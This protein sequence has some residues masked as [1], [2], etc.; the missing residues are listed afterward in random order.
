M[1]ASLLNEE[2][3]TASLEQRTLVILVG[4]F[5][6][7]VDLLLDIPLLVAD[8]T[9]TTDPDLVIDKAHLAGHGCRQRFAAHDDSGRSTRTSDGCLNRT[10]GFD[11]RRV[12]ICIH[13]TPFLHASEVTTAC[14]AVRHVFCKYQSSDHAAIPRSGTT[15]RGTNHALDDC[16]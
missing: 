2:K 9:R 12:G 8:K 4:R 16:S 13:V 10:I 14:H 11:A 3:V 5:P 7:I 1:F 6:A 15:V